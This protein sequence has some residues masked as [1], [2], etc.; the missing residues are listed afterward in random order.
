VNFLEDFE[1]VRW[2]DIE[3][4]RQAGEATLGKPKQ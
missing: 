1:D 2:Y 3:A 4:A